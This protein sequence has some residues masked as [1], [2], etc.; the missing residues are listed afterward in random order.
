MPQAVDVLG[1]GG[2]AGH[3]RPVAPFEP[4]PSVE[5]ERS[6]FATFIQEHT[7]VVGDIRP[8]RTPNPPDTILYDIT[9][10][11]HDLWRDHPVLKLLGIRW[12]QRIA[13]ESLGVLYADA[14]RAEMHET[15]AKAVRLVVFPASGLETSNW[16]RWVG[17]NGRAIV[18]VAISADV[19]QRLGAGA[20]TNRGM[21]FMFELR[22]AVL[23]VINAVKPPEGAW[24]A[25]RV[26][27][28][29]EPHMNDTTTTDGAALQS[30]AHPDLPQLSPDLHAMDIARA[31]VGVHYPNAVAALAANPDNE[32]TLA[33]V[34]ARA[35][36][37]LS[38]A[39]A[40]IAMFN[41]ALNLLSAIIPP[42]TATLPVPPPNPV[43]EHGESGQQPAST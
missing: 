16:S 1:L 14:I 12:R 42:S 35:Q 28:R 29:K 24:Q 40:F 4:R 41:T 18:E 20:V 22:D 5:R 25:D 2:F 36:S 31:A 6:D 39:K 11:T 27:P 7:A 21:S 17:E 34:E 26:K 19:K 38:D 33:Y 30:A 43:P 8:E 15:V 3:A 37:Y 23:A 9:I 32:D 10:R 13:S